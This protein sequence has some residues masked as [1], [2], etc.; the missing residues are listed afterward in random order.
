MTPARNSPSVMTEI[1]ADSGRWLRR[2][3]RR[4]S[5]PR[6]RAA[7]ASRVVPRIAERRLR[8]VEVGS[9]RITVDR[10]R[11]DAEDRLAVDVGTRAARYRGGPS[12]ATGRPRTVTVKTVPA[13]A[14]R[15]MAATLLRRSRWG[16]VRLDMTA[17]QRSSPIGRI[18]V[19]GSRRLRVSNAERYPP[20]SFDIAGPRCD[21]VC[22]LTD[23][24]GR[25]QGD[26]RCRRGSL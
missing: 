3:L 16:I 26:R 13:S 11:E 22:Q 6:C 20:G 17:T 14:S 5:G 9:Q 12:C 23:L 1:A 10:Q 4:R 24:E 21:W 19:I 15:R 2:P 25:S 8:G 7:R 18:R